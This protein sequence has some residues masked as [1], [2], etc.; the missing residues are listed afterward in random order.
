MVRLCRNQWNPDTCG[1]VV[2]FEFDADLPGET[3]THKLVSLIPCSAH[4]GDTAYINQT[5]EAATIPVH[6]ENQRKNLGL[7][8]L[9]TEV[10]LPNDGTR[11]EK[12]QVYLDR[13]YYDTASPRV[14]HIVTKGLSTQQKNRAQSAVNN[15][16]GVGLIVIE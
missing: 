13:W 15:R 2:E 12:L 14:L 8:E 5:L 9:A 3:R 4:T 7:D 10:G 11:W 6:K 16:F 1:C